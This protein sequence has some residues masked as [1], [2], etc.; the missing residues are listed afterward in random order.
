MIREERPRRVSLE[1]RVRENFDLEQ[2]ELQG[3]SDSRPFPFHLPEIL[4]GG[5]LKNKLSELTGQDEA[6]IP[7]SRSQSINPRERAAAIA[8][9]LFL[10]PSFR[11]ALR[12]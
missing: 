11:M 2:P 10:A 6:V 1:H 8:W 4:G 12:R 5:D 7:T 9:A 3:F